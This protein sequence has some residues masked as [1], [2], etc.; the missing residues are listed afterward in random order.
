[1]RLED[2]Q[3]GSIT[4]TLKSK[5]EEIQYNCFKCDFQ[6]TKEIELK[7]HISLKHEIEGKAVDHSDGLIKCRNCGDVF[8]TKWNLMNHRKSEHL[9]IV[10]QCRNYLEG[11]CVYTDSMCW[12]K[13]AERAASSETHIACFI[14][15]KNFISKPLMMSHRKRD[16]ADV[17][18]PCN[19]YLSNECKFQ[20]D[21]CCIL[22]FLCPEGRVGYFF[23]KEPSI[24]RCNT[25]YPTLKPQGIK[26]LS[27]TL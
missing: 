10:A 20:D 9:N 25:K 13:H 21:S 26:V 17:L 12:W 22:P 3:N 4:N 24:K 5:D 11:K 7:K 16:H 6:G 19:K 2:P 14:C 1:M 27:K 23:Y 8:K 15:N 18:R